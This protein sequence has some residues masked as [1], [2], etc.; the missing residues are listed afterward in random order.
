LNEKT[1][2]EFRF[3]F[4]NNILNYIYKFSATEKVV[5]GFVCIVFIISGLILAHKALNIFKIDMPK[6]S[7]TIE[8]GI[9]GL[10]RLI[11]P[12]LATSEA[13]KDI[14]SIVFSGLMKYDNGKMVPDIAKSWTV[15]EDGLVY[16]FILRDDVYFHDNTK[17][18][19]DDVIF[20]IQK[21][22]DPVIKSPRRADWQNI[23][24]KKI[25]DFEIQFLLKQPYSPFITITSVG[26]LPKHI[27]SN[28][29]DEE[30]VFSSLNTKPIG[31]GPFKY[32]DVSMNKGGVLTRIG[33]KVLT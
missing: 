28:V 31:S 1:K 9:V 5:F 3:N 13:D 21:I 16:D 30:F 23:S 18:T 10:P 11:N 17:L 26:I 27:W 15:S 29:S 6:Y 33:L 20:T 8:E 24:V 7:G 14:S 25:S 2:K 12:V 32:E 22:Q 19:S 4:G